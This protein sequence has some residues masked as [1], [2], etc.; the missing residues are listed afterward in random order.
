MT[1]KTT[2]AR[3]ASN[4]AI[5]VV[6]LKKTKKGIQ[7]AVRRK[8]AG[9][10]A[11]TGMREG[12]TLEQ[13]EDAKKSFDKLVEAATSKGWTPSAKVQKSAFTEMPA[14]PTPAATPAP[15]APTPETPAP[16]PK[17]GAKK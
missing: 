14:P 4:G 6:S 5:L 13:A 2:N 12:F 8:L 16:A 3:F 7:V 1:I 15:P 9:N 10:K 17:N 11:E